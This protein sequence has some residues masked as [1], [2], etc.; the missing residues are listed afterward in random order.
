MWWLQKHLRHFL[1]HC[2]GESNAKTFLLPT[3]F[4][5]FS[6][7]IYNQCN[8]VLPQTYLYTC[9][10]WKVTARPF[11]SPLPSPFP[12]PFPPSQLHIC[13]ASSSLILSPLLPLL[14]FLRLLADI[15]RGFATSLTSLWF[16]IPAF[17]L[18]AFRC[19][20]II[21]TFTTFWT[22]HCD[23][24]PPL[25]TTFFLFAHVTSSFSTF[26]L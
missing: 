6:G 20:N 23:F 16:C 26:E 9:L 5:W 24:F 7:H 17:L 10:V 12:P 14:Y 2:N 25:T 8:V 4:R 21:V 11:V 19:V 1:Y 15:A 18:F 3:S 22:I 13:I